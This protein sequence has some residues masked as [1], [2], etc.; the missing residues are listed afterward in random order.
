MCLVPSLCCAARTADGERAMSVEVLVDEQK[1]A[2]Q[3]LHLDQVCGNDEAGHAHL[4]SVPVIPQDTSPSTM[5]H[6][7]TGLLEG[8]ALQPTVSEILEVA[9][10]SSK[11][12]QNDSIRCSRSEVQERVRGSKALKTSLEHPDFNGKWKMVACEG[13]FDAFMK[14]MGV[15]WA[16]R[17]AAQAVSYGCGSTFHTVEHTEEHFKVETKNPKGTFVRNFRIDGSEQDD[18]DPVEKKHIKVVPFW[19][20]LEDKTVLTVEA[21]MPMANGDPRKFPLTRRYMRDASMIVEQVSPAG[22]K[23]MRVFRRE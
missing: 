22:V 11:N 7:A 2:Q 17:K 14:E 6:G 8:I 23:I 1:E 20:A 13:D 19:E 12:A 9:S 16:L 5:G 15:A 21:Y 3:R 10:P 18:E 4:V